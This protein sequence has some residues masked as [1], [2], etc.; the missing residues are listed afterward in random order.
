MSVHLLKA[1]EHLN[2]RVIELSTI[3][4]ES[5]QRAVEALE[6]RNKDLALK[7]IEDDTIID[8][9]EVDVEEECLKILALHQP[10]ASDLRFIVAVLKINND[11]ERVGDLAVNVAE[12]AAYLATLKPIDVALDFHAMARKTQWMLKRALDALVDQDPDLAKAVCQAD[13]EVDAMNREMYERVQ[14]GIRRDIEAMPALIHL[15]SVSRHLERIAD[16]A[17]NIAE[18]VVYM[19]RGEIIRHKVEQYFHETGPIRGG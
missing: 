3:V 12:R 17:T 14:E 11:L 8:E 19:A 7:V 1:V 18:D 16:L 10:V 13:D 4:E 2:K 5:V 15:L 9:M 6:T